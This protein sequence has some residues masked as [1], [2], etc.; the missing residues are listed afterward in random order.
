MEAHSLSL[1]EK[2]SFD[3]RIGSPLTGGSHN[4][5]SPDSIISGQPRFN[6]LSVD[7]ASSPGRFDYQHQGPTT[8][9]VKKES[10]NRLSCGK[11]SQTVKLSLKKPLSARSLKSHVI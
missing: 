3:F 7:D 4:V 6:W 5:D 1:S 11:G 2:Y 8:P 10:L 9:T